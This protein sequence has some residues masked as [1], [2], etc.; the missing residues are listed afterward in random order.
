MGKLQ[1][2]WQRF[3]IRSVLCYE[4]NFD[5]FAINLL[6]G[7]ITGAQIAPNAPACAHGISFRRWETFG[8]LEEIWRIDNVRMP[9]GDVSRNMLTSYYISPISQ[10]LGFGWADGALG[11]V[12]G[13]W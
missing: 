9:F 13:H 10:R 7:E 4:V 3:N 11:L 5:E 12:F 6:G 1:I 8:S 2:D